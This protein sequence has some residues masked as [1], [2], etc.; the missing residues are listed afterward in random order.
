MEKL[1]V[2]ISWSGD[3][4]VAATGEA[5]GAVFATSKTFEGAKKAFADALQFHL[6]DD[7]G[8]APQWLV[9]GGY[10]TEYQLE[11]SAI[12]HNLDGVVT[13]SAISRVTGINVKQIGHYA[14]GI[15]NPRPEQRKKIIEGIHR[16]GRE[17]S[18]V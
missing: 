13:R 2:K 6:E 18:S 14:M 15:R 11:I 10:E 16:L 17:L 4:Y 9:S 5:G 3:N 8:D 1:I 12:L 7:E